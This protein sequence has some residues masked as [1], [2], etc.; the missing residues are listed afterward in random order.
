LAKNNFTQW[1]TDMIFFD[2]VSFYSTP[3]YYVQKLFSNNQGDIY[4]SNVITKDNKDTALAASCVQD[5]KTGDIILK[6]VN[7]GSEIKTMKVDLTS[8]RQLDANAEKTILT[9]LPE[10]ENS[11][12]NRNNI[13]P[14]SATI[15]ISKK[16][17]YP[18]PAMSLTV[19]RIKKK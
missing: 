13:V 5:N 11:F 19:I 18:A 7:F 2:N 14:V 3:N 16:F 1:K 9:G 10:A 15:K 12:E 6:L 4:F 8:F 17:D